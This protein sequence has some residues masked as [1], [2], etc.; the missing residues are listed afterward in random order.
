LFNLTKL[1]EYTAKVEMLMTIDEFVIDGYEGPLCTVKEMLEPIFTDFT[2]TPPAEV[3]EVKP[4]A[5]IGV[6]YGFRYKAPET[7]DVEIWASLYNYTLG[8]LNRQEQAQTKEMITLEKA[9]TFQIYYG[10]I[11]IVVGEVGAGTYGLI[12]ELPDYDVEDHIDNCVE[13]TVPPIPPEYELAYHHEYPRG[14]TY[15]GKAEECTATLTIPLPEQLFPNNWV[16]ERIADAFADEVAKEGGEMLDIKIYEDAT[17]TWHTDYRIV[18]TATAS[19]IPWA[20]IIPLVLAIILVVAF[21][22]LV[23]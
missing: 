12:C 2:I 9:L 21:T 23:I 11:G 10:E 7:C 17:P 18:A 14:K 4:G 5:K 20:I 16:R 1:G 3:L 19:P 13:V 15:V 6:P 8:I 22:N